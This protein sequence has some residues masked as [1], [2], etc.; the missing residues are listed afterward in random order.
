MAANRHSPARA[1]LLLATILSP[2]LLAAEARAQLAPG[3]EHLLRV[4][5]AGGVVVPTSDARNALKNGVQ[6]QGFVL[7]N[8]LPGLPLRFNLGY[9]KFN[10]KDALTAGGAVDGDTRILSGV[11]GAQLNLLRGPLRPYITAGL[12]G[13]N[14][15]QTLTST[16]SPASVSNS[17]FKFGVDGG[18]GI[19]L[20]IGRIAAFVEGKVQNIYTDQGAINVKSI[21]AVPVSFGIIF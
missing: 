6:G 16:A 8:L 3:G 11:A 9:Q 12:G 15:Q 18:A 20:N 4:G 2:L 21:Q 17:Q 10:L 13:F 5:F 14:V 19:A 1:L 7:L